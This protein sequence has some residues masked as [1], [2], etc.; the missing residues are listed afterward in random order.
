MRLQ[1]PDGDASGV[2]AELLK[3]DLGD[4]FPVSV[5][6][7]ILKGQLMCTWGYLKGHRGLLDVAF[8][9][10]ELQHHVVL[11]PGLGCSR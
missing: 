4:I 2:G 1:T 5:D 3:G 8:W 10:L 6:D 9:S 7:L 11:L